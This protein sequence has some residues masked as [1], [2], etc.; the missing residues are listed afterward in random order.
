MSLFENREVFSDYF[1][2]DFFRQYFANLD[3]TFLEALIGRL[4][5]EDEDDAE[6]ESRQINDNVVGN[7]AAILLTDDAQST[8]NFLYVNPIE[9]FNNGRASDI[10]LDIAWPS[11]EASDDS[12]PSNIDASSVDAELATNNLDAG[13]DGSSQLNDNLVG[14]NGAILMTDDAQS[15]VNF[16]YINPIEFFNNGRASDI[17]ININSGDEVTTTTVSAPEAVALADDPGGDAGPTAVTTTDA[18]GFAGFAAENGAAPSE[19]VDG[20]FLDSFGFLDGSDFLNDFS[21][22]NDFDFLDVLS[23][24]DQV[25]LLDGFGFP[26]DFGFLDGLDFL[27]EFIFPGTDDGSDASDGLGLGLDGLGLDGLDDFGQVN[28]NVVGNNAAILLTDNAQSTVNFLYINP[29]QFFNDGRGGDIHLNI[30]LD[31][32]DEFHIL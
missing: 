21:F 5:G 1:R 10:Y 8:V 18:S 26:D 23:F 4:L 31:A 22:L 19:M 16:L 17:D 15:T 6:S 11:S 30:S 32:G 12:S 29:I 2:A 24:L 7:N 25:D 27:D 14:N 28:D 13:S 20:G 3:A 9:F